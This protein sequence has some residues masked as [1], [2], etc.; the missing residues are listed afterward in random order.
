MKI[1]LS[2]IATVQ[3]GIYAKPELA[4]EVYYVQARHFDHHHQFNTF[5]KPD[6]KAD[7]K[8]EKH[9]LQAGDLLVA[10]K[11][12]DHFAVEYKGI[13]K[14]AVASSMFMVV[15]LQDSK[16]LP[17]FLTWFINNRQTQRLL[18]DSA[19]GTALPAITNSDLGNLEIPLP[20]IEK[21]KLILQIHE[22]HLQ[23]N[24]LREQINELRGKQIHQQ[25]M[26]SLN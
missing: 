23:E 2:D 12:S 8:I 19:Q 4:G 7:S 18:S 13:I 15:K 14:P 1:K 22:L 17:A 20:T 3:S 21:Q 9:F 5:V 10:A 24:R 26:N 16:I 11:G 6:L 25:V